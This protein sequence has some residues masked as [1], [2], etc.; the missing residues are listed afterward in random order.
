MTFFQRSNSSSTLHGSLKDG[1]ATPWQPQVKQKFFDSIKSIRFEDYDAANYLESHKVGSR[2]VGS[3]TFDHQ[4]LRCRKG[5][6]VFMAFT[7]DARYCMICNRRFCLLQTLSVT[8]LCCSATGSQMLC[9]GF[10]NGWNQS[11]LIRVSGYRLIDRKLIFHFR[12]IDC[13]KFW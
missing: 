6:A 5:F 2:P 13:C 7:N 10:I 8:L 11:H 1:S 12:L 4:L 3:I 9:H